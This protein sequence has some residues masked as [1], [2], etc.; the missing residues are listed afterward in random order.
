M[1][2]FDTA[3]AVRAQL[4]KILSSK[5]FAGGER[6]AGFLRFV[7]EKTLAGQ[8]DQIKEYVIAVE[9]LGRKP[10]FDPRRLTSTLL[11]SNK[12]RR[13]SCTQAA[14]LLTKATMFHS[15]GRPTASRSSMHRT[16]TGRRIFSNRKSGAVLPT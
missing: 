8:A 15:I 14:S 2:R 4:E 3:A 11:P 10:S 7:V 16:E 13:G 1:E 12:T 9:V 6:A 5:L